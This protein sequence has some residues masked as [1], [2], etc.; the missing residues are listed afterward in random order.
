MAA[1]AGE[2]ENPSPAEQGR[3]TPA[4]RERLE[5]C[6]EA[7]AIAA[8]ARAGCIEALAEEFS[9]E[10]PYRARFFRLLA[11]RV[12]PL[13]PVVFL[14]IVHRPGAAPGIDIKDAWAW[15]E[16]D[17]RGLQGL[18]PSG[19]WQGGAESFAEKFIKENFS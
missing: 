14:P 12:L 16:G 8:E 18:G 11:G 13:R 10:T 4:V 6:L 3:L 15:T 5:A 9:R 1:A 2:D 17:A 19:S 7:M